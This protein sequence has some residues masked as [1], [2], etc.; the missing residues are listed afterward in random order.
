[1]ALL[2]RQWP[3]DVSV[4]IAI[5][6]T[7]IIAQLEEAYWVI[8]KERTRLVRKYGVRVGEKMMVSPDADNA[9]DFALDF[10]EFLMQE[11]GN[12]KIEKVKLPRKI[13]SKCDKCGQ[14]TEILFQIEPNL[15]VL[16]AEHFIEVV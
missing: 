8:D 2:K 14:E 10:G 11:C 15:L 1:M 9:G 12:I 13:T 4:A 5:S 6:I 7:K 3:V 16:L